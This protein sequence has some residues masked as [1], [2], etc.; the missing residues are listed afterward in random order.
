MNYKLKIGGAIRL[1]DAGQVVEHIT[2]ADRGWSAFLAWMAVGNVPLQSDTGIK[3][4]ELDIFGPLES[5]PF[6]LDHP[7]WQPANRAAA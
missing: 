1:D 3:L 4:V 7:V 6:P 2:P 5:L